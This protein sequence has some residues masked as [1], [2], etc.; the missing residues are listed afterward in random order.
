VA[1]DLK[2]LQQQLAG[3]F[4][5]E[6][7]DNIERLEAG[8]LRLTS[9]RGDAGLIDDIFRAAHSIKG[10]AGTFGFVG[11][12]RVAHAL[13]NVLDRFRQ[14]QVTPTAAEVA[15]LLET[16]DGLRTLLS[17]H[18][19][20][21]AIDEGVV[22]A[23]CARLAATDAAAA[24]APPAAAGSAW[25]IQLRP[26]LHLLQS[27]NEPL[28]LLRELERMGRITVVANAERL[29]PW[30][31][32]DPESCYLSWSVRLDGAVTRAAVDEV[33]AW[34]DGD[35]TVV[36]EPVTSEPAEAAV[37]LPA[38]RGKGEEVERRESAGLGSVRVPVDKIDLLMNMVGELVITQSMLGTLDGDGPVDSQRLER[39]REGLPQLARN[40]RLLQESVM[41]LR[42]M[43]IGLVFSRFPRLVHDLTA[44]LHKQ[45]DL[46]ISG[47][48]TELD[49]TVLEKLGDP[50]VH[51][52]RN[53]LD[54]GLESPEARAAAS[55]PETG[56]LEL[57]AFHRGSDIVIEVADD[58][59]GL[60]AER[61]LARARERGL[62][63][64][65]QVLTEA[66]I[67]GLIFLPGFST[68]STVTDVSGRGVG[69]DVVRRS[70]R[71]LG[72]DVLVESHRGRGTRISLR[73]PL[74]L[75]IIDGQLFR[76]TKHIYVLPL[77]AI[78][79]CIQV[80]GRQI[81]RL[82]GGQRLYRLRQAFIPMLDLGT[83]FGMPPRDGDLSGS[84][85]VVVENE[86][87]AFGLLVDELLAQQQ[88]VVK[89]LEANYARVEGLAGATVLGDGGVAFIV[90]VA[91]I[92]KLAGASHRDFGAEKGRSVLA[93]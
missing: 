51:L 67:H 28:R 40:T 76:L 42:S 55:K 60:D 15:V 49:K 41:R 5:E 18:R 85:L 26:E 58:G 44:K 74:T 70:V 1:S 14:E 56:V 3:V 35:A 39:L 8:C 20:D 75:A 38:T 31:A 77:A 73:L 32:Y 90:D 81:N 21:V 89:S 88:V 16:V 37:A 62:V 11:V 22:Q 54:H 30:T 92:A 19:D 83:L 86:G 46:R 36:T 93:A 43:P 78:V 24:E 65:E 80:D 71:S 10:G 91:G 33:F 23:L 47:E 79:E 17:A 2:S 45:V 59:C 29:P 50:L 53:S 82:P 13:E 12:S 69:M 9:V 7:L 4:F 52:V 27:G 72:G 48:T 68:A 57:R 64:P 25:Q 61:I 63:G 87:Q 34:L 84:L 66:E 6:S